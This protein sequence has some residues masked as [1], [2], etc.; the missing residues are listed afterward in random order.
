MHDDRWSWK[1]MNDQ[2]LRIA[3]EK[4]LRRSD[5][6]GER[7]LDTDLNLFKVVEI[8][9][10]GLAGIFGWRPGFKGR[11]LRVET[12][13]QFDQRLSLE[14]AKRYVVDFLSAHPEVYSSGMSP[15]QMLSTVMS[16]ASSEELLA[17]L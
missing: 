3:T 16:A 5:R 6:L 8:R 15:E 11:H 14:A 13:L 4:Y 10:Q 17:S 1:I 7:I 9:E 2:P 12:V